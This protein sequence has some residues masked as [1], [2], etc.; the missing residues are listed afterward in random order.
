MTYKEVAEAKT[1]LVFFDYD[2]GAV[3][4]VPAAFRERLAAL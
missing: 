4:D 1:G 2:A 3:R